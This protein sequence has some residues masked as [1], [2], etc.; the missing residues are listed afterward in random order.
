MNISMNNYTFL[1]YF[2]NSLC[3]ACSFSLKR[4]VK[5]ILFLQT[6]VLLFYVFSMILYVPQ[7]NDHGIKFAEAFEKYSQT[8]GPVWTRIWTWCLLL[9]QLRIFYDSALFHCK[10][11]PLLK[12]FSW[13]KGEILMWYLKRRDVRQN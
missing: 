7:G 13:F 9:F 2:F 12:V 1:P 3:W 6:D 4:K 5:Q 8:C 11:S 10:I